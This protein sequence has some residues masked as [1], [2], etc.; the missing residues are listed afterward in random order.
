MAGR[1]VLELRIEIAKLVATASEAIC[2]LVLAAVMVY[3][4][5]RPFVR[6]DGDT[7]CQYLV[8]GPFGGGITPRLDKGQHM[9]CEE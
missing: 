9:G 7:G 6:T 8:S 4:A 5:T 2:L 3:S 1:K